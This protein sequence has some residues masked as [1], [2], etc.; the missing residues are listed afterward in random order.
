MGEGG[1][2]DLANAHLL[3]QLVIISVGAILV[4]REMD[5]LGRPKIVRLLHGAHDDAARCNASGTKIDSM[6]W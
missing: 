2:G 6:R 3:G 4:L 1:H 5:L